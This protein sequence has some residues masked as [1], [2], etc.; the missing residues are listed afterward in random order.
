M[1]FSAQHSEAGTNE[2]GQGIHGYGSVRGA[3][4]DVV[5]TVSVVVLQ[6]ELS[7]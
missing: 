7:G 5:P 1:T 3:I 2:H 6:R 4:S